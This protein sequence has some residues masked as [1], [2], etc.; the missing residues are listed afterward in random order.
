MPLCN[1]VLGCLASAVDVIGPHDI[2]STAG[3]PSRQDD[4][5]E[6]CADD[7]VAQQGRQP[8]AT[9]QEAADTPAPVAAVDPGQGRSTILTLVEFRDPGGE[10]LLGPVRVHEV[11]L[12][13]ERFR[14]PLPW[15]VSHLETNNGCPE[16]AGM[17]RQPS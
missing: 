9:G 6:L 16:R 12:A 2:D 3:N 17:P 5:W 14:E 13:L 11:E 7:Q 10:Q 1:E 15:H 4:S 8:Y